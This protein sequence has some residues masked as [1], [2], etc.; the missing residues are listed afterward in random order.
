VGYFSP[1]PELAV[2]VSVQAGDLL[3][4]V[5]VLGIEQEVVAPDD[6]V[7]ARVLAEDG[8]AVEYGQALA[9]IDPMPSGLHDGDDGE[10]A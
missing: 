10:A 3:G 5:D 1:A 8:Q 2:G 4:L 9:E 7:I 6:G